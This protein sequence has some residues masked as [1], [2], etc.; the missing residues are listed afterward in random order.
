MQS[1]IISYGAA[2]A[3]LVNAFCHE[4]AEGDQ[5]LEASLPTGNSEARTNSGALKLKRPQNNLSARLKLPSDP[6]LA[7]AKVKR[8]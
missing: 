7:N 4:C 6:R 8:Y 5:R 1:K 2:L 3:R